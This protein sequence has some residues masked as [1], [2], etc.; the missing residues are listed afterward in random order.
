MEARAVWFR[1]QC[2]PVSHTREDAG[3]LP[4]PTGYRLLVVVPCPAKPLPYPRKEYDNGSRIGEETG[5]VFS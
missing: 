2:R 1:G 5:A 3:I 4:L